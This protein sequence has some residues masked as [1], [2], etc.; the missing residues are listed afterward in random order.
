MESSRG[1]LF[2]D[3]VVD[4]FIFKNKQIS[5]SPCFTFIP[6]TG[7]G[8]PETGF[9]LCATF[10]RPIERVGWVLLSLDQKYV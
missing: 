8:V 6:K 2:I 9:L 5:H 3:M 1:N 10:W 4:R 7:A